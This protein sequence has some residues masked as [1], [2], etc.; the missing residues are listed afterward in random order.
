MTAQRVVVDASIALAWFLPDSAQPETVGG[1]VSKRH[2]P[3]N[4]WQQRLSDRPQLETRR[5]SQSG[6]VW[7]G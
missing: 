1:C 6:V 7:R 5:R 2:I 3:Y 4:R